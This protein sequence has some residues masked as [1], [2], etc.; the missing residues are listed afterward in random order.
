LSAGAAPPL[1]AGA[2]LVFAGS[3]PCVE[4][5][6]PHAA[7]IPIDTQTTPIPFRPLLTRFFM[8]ILVI[9]RPMTRGHAGAAVATAGHLHELPAAGKSYPPALLDTPR[10]IWASK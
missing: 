9:E 3:V 8:F 1:A 7:A 6:P 10:G 2:A 4:L 5:A